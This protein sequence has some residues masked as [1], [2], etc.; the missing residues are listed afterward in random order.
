MK[1]YT[2]KSL[3]ISQGR[4]V[5]KNDIKYILS[6]MIIYPKQITLNLSSNQ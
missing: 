1:W 6:W 3:C 2:Y 4:F 5:S